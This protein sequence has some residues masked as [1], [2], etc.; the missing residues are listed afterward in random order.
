[1]EH[2]IAGECQE[3]N[4][5]YDTDFTFVLCALA[6]RTRESPIWKIWKKFLVAEWS[7]GDG[8]PISADRYI[9]NLVTRIAFRVTHSPSINER[10][11]CGRGESCVVIFSLRSEWCIRVKVSRSPSR[12]YILKHIYCTYVCVRMC[13][14]FAAIIV[15]LREVGIITNSS[16]EFR[17]EEM[18]EHTSDVIMRNLFVKQVVGTLAVNPCRGNSHTECAGRD[19]RGLDVFDE[20]RGDKKR[21]TRKHPFAQHQCLF[22]VTVN[23]RLDN[24]THTYIML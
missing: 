12:N 13:V 17:R 9:L 16:H 2:V 20:G 23:V 3:C 22:S 8:P 1:M 24:L 15:Q 21:R 19:W 7:S 6:V 14:A 4:G 11:A 5:R 18:L 10:G